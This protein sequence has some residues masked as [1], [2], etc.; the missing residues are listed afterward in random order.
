MSAVINCLAALQQL[1]PSQTG[2]LPVGLAACWQH[3]YTCMSSCCPG[4]AEWLHQVCFA[5]S[6]ICQMNFARSQPLSDPGT[7]ELHDS[8]SVKS[9][10]SS[11]HMSTLA[12]HLHKLLKA[13]AVQA[14]KVVS[15]CIATV[16]QGT[17][18]V[19]SS[20]SA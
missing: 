12:V 16:L 5:R 17:L 9:S 7:V 15:Y 1:D 10:Y 3:F 18:L 11:N 4:Q 20:H 19:T 2:L 6:I 14:T 8:C 13:A